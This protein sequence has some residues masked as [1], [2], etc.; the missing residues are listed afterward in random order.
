MSPCR[1]ISRPAL[2]GHAGVGLRRL[3]ALPGSR[4]FDTP[5]HAAVTLGVVFA[6]ALLV[7][8]PLN[9]SAGL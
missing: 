2:K 3:Q 6:G 5:L 1:Q 7:S 4:F 9:L 8:E